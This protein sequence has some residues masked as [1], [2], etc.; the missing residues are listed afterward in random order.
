MI[1]L[2]L[3]HDQKE[4]TILVGGNLD[5]IGGN[6]YVGSHNYFVTEACEYRDSFLELRPNIEI[7]LNIDSDHLDYFKDVEHIARSFERFARL[8]PENGAVILSK[9]NMQLMFL[10]EE[11]TVTSI[12]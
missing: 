8:V 7:I 3:K 4:P 9:G 2:I 10:M 11:G 1:S 5:E 6:C 12:L